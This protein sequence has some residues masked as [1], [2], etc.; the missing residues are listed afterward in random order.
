VS[1]SELLAMWDVP[2]P[3]DMLLSSEAERRDL[4]RTCSFPLKIFERVAEKMRSIWIPDV[5]STTLPVIKTVS[6]VSSF[7]TEGG[8]V[9]L[10]VAANAA[11]PPGAV[12][13]IS[14]FPSGCEF[15]GSVTET[16]ASQA[17]K[18]VL[19][20][21]QKENPRICG[22]VGCCALTT[23][24][25]KGNFRKLDWK[26]SFGVLRSA[27]LRFWKKSLLRGFFRYKSKTEGESGRELPTYV[28]GFFISSRFVL[29]LGLVRFSGSGKKSFER[30]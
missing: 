20:Q 14:K 15:V 30:I 9:R 19:D 6:H 1:A 5:T 4:F 17:L 22:T 2:E 7:Q 26:R 8:D 28:K 13:G 25:D 16:E 24:D 27:M 11:V 12:A 10:G 21:L 3:L 18:E 23:R 29:G